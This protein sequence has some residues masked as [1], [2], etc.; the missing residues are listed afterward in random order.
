MLISSPVRFKYSLR[1]VRL[2]T[3]LIET[4]R[5]D[6]GHFLYKDHISKALANGDIVPIKLEKIAESLNGIQ[7]ALD[8]PLTIN[9]KKLLVN[10]WE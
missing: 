9:G 6:L 2:L 10:P 3:S 4:D 1:L 7:E 8:L 5:K